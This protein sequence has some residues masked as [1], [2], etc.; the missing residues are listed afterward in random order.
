MPN[1]ST[2]PSPSLK[3]SFV[4]LALEH[5]HPEVC[6]LDQ[7][8]E[9]TE[10]SR[11]PPAIPQPLCPAVNPILDMIAVLAHRS[12]AYDRRVEALCEQW[13]PETSLLRSPP[14]SLT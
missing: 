11:I 4:G 1:N 10:Q 6:I 3:T 2:V 14:Y 7:D 13:Y 8:A 9:V 12:Q 5:K